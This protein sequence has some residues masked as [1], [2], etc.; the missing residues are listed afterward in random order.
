MT[1]AMAMPKRTE[2]RVSRL[3]LVDYITSWAQ[4]E[5]KDM[6]ARVVKEFANEIEKEKLVQ[7]DIVIAKVP[8]NWNPMRTDSI[9][10]PNHHEFDEGTF[11]FGRYCRE[12]DVLGINCYVYLMPDET[13]AVCVPH[14]RVVSLATI[15]IS[16]PD[17]S[18]LERMVTNPFDAFSTELRQAVKDTT[19][20]KLSDLGLDPDIIN[21]S[22]NFNG[23]RCIGLD[24]L[25]TLKAQLCAFDGKEPFLKEIDRVSSYFSQFFA[26]Y[27]KKVFLNESRGNHQLYFTRD[28]SFKDYT[29]SSTIIEYNNL[30]G[31]GNNN[32]NKEINATTTEEEFIKQNNAIK[33]QLQQQQQTSTTTEGECLD[34][35]NNNNRK[36]DNSCTTKYFSMIKKQYTKFKPFLPTIRSLVSDLENGR[37]MCL[38]AK[39]SLQ[40]LISEC[41]LAIDTVNTDN[42]RLLDGSKKKELTTWWLQI[43]GGSVSSYLT[44]RGFDPSAVPDNYIDERP[45]SLSMVKENLRIVNLVLKPSTQYDIEHRLNYLTLPLKVKIYHRIDQFLLSAE[46]LLFDR[47]KR[48][49]KLLEELIINGSNEQQKEQ[50]KV[51][52]PVKVADIDSI[53]REELEDYFDLKKLLTLS[54]S[55]MQSDSTLAPELQIVSIWYNLI[56]DIMYIREMK[57]LEEHFYSNDILLEVSHPI[58]NE[59]FTLSNIVPITGLVFSRLLRI[60]HELRTVLEVHGEKQISTRS[61]FPNVVHHGVII[62]KKDDK[63]REKEKDRDKDKDRD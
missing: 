37:I 51:P 26:N 29:L 39:D 17:R 54:K 59:K 32:N 20:D 16:L 8:K 28:Q 24:E 30:F 12:A 35:N 43:I 34:N 7:G 40:G 14:S 49:K 21:Q 4:I 2:L 31:G 15:G 42:L 6:L 38:R 50:G 58:T 19:R 33:I 9:I 5:D 1:G 62:G 3:T 56:E 55:R 57:N 52:Q 10:D 25:T 48:N 63:D 61:L 44:D 27:L 53:S 60:K 18:K 22:L 46:I 45:A 11:L 36:E 41:D 23:V 47:L 13:N